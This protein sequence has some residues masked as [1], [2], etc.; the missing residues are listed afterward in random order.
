MTPG[1]DSFGLAINSKLTATL[2]EAM[3]PAL[4][5][6]ANFRLAEGDNAIPGTVSYD[7]TNH[8]AVFTPTSSF[9]PNTRF[10]ATIVTGIK[11][12]GNNPLTTDFAWCFSTGGSADSTPPSVISKIPA[13]AGTGVAVNRRITA[14][15]SEEMN[16]STLTAASFAVTGPGP[17]PVSGT[18]TYSG[19]TAVFTP[20]P[21]L[22]PNTTYTATIG[23]LRLIWQVIP[24]RRRTQYGA[25]PPVQAPMSPHR[26][27]MSPSL[28]APRRT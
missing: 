26:L 8:I 19:R 24:C 16:S 1:E 2:S 5:N 9:A 11:D 3:D 12:L 7:S 20:S 4:I 14:T 27:S 15:F 21:S 13:S 17:T 22:A 23:T 28:T 10:T 18:V 6:T 25:L